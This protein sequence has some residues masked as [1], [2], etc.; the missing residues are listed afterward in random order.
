MMMMMMMW[1]AISI[2][3]LSPTNLN[4][5]IR[6]II[7]KKSYAPSDLIQFFFCMW[8]KNIYVSIRFF[9]NIQHHTQFA[10]RIK[11]FVCYPVI[12][13]V[14]ISDEWF[15]RNSTDISIISVKSF[16]ICFKVIQFNMRMRTMSFMFTCFFYQRNSSCWS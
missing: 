6:W 2:L 5:K 13:N 15:E 4:A 11:D 10:R 1:N 7:S 14:K 3:N 16:K 8:R 12:K 9:F